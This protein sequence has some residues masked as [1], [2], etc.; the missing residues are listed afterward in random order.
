MQ[1][2]VRNAIASIHDRY[3]EPLTLTDLASEVFVSPFHFSRIFA[4]ATGIT[5]GRYLTAV[6]MFE[7]KRLLLTSSLTVSDIVCSVGYS[8]VGTFTSRF[9]RAVGRSPSQYRD[10]EVRELLMAI[11]PHYQRL[12]SPQAL[13]EAGMRDASPAGTGGSIK[14]SIEMPPGTEPGNVLVGAFAERIPQCG[15]VAFTATSNA[16]SANIELTDVPPG[17][18]TVLAA[19][20]SHDTACPSFCLGTAGRS[21]TVGRGETVPVHIPMRPLQPTDPPI[22][23]TLASC[24]SAAAG[25]SIAAGRNRPLH[26]AA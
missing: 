17:R 24:P 1:P 16:L 2:A 5:P 13:R 22:A 4:K 9:T 14:V 7:A 20:E 11:A 12:P 19:A 25:T 26:L 23:I 10:A 3:F 15:P 18:W 6:R 8:S 21:V